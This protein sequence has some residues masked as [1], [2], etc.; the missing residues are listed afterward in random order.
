[1]GQTL[2]PFPYAYG[3]DISQHKAVSWANGIKADKD[4]SSV[5]HGLVTF[6]IYPHGLTSVDCKLVSLS[7]K[8]KIDNK[9]YN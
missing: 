3:S 4:E 1:M 6:G 5:S 8:V 7:C 2:N 9:A